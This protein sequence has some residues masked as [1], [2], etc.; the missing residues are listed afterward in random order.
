[1]WIRFV[2]WMIIGELKGLM[3]GIWNDVIVEIFKIVWN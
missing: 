1:M 3:G 2:V